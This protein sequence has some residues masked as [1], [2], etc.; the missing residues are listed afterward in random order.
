M[1]NYIEDD[2]NSFSKIK[3][4]EYDNNYKVT[5]CYVDITS[6]NEEFNKII[7]GDND[8]ILG[9][10]IKNNNENICNIDL[11]YYNLKINIPY[12]NNF[13]YKKYQLFPTNE[14]EE[15]DQNED[16]YENFIKLSEINYNKIKIL[17]IKIYLKIN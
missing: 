3:E 9:N 11:K 8:I 16:K 10:L 4:I 13:I 6:I 17:K 7:Y 14:N 5:N 15:E 12:N 2:I 1:W